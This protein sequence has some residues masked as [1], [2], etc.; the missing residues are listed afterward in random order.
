MRDKLVMKIALMTWFSYYNYGTQ[1]QAISLYNTLSQYGD[2]D[3]IRY[4]PGLGRKP[5]TIS[6]ILP[7]SLHKLNKND[8]DVLQTLSS[9]KINHFRDKY[10][11]YS[12]KSQTKQELD[13]LNDKY[14]A[15][16]CGSD[17]IWSPLNFDPHYYLDFVKDPRKLIAYAPSMGV[18]HIDDGQ[19]SEQIRLLSSRFI[20]LSVRE[21]S[22]AKILR[23][24]GEN[25]LVTV[26]PTMLLT[27]EQ[28][29]A[30]ES[31]LGKGENYL[32]M[33]F[34]R[35]N[36][37]HIQSAYTIAE[38]KHLKVRIIPVVYGQLRDDNS[39]NSGL[40][41]NDF[42]S[43]FKNAAYIC[44]DSFHGTIFSLIYNKSFTT[45]ERFR[46]NEKINQNSRIYNLLGSVDLD[47]RIYH[48]DKKT[49]ITEIDFRGVNKKIEKM[50]QDSMIFLDKSIKR[51]ESLERI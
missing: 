4:T 31:G 28:W 32:L 2:V 45:Y 46:S 24:F 16:V 23:R 7:R 39:I 19:I 41:P 40:G 8:H 17:Q 5:L 29:D 1:L 47:N 50:K 6:N 44:T 13:A 38:Q 48:R 34:L 37:E 12:K 20:S 30:Y 15:F 21:E 49:D 33:Y 27:S 22:G 11:T 3:I 51:I 14:D 26:D 43:L 9:E 18:E 35:Y 10:I 25:P 42:I 36:K